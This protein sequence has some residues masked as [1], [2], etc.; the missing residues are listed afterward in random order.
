MSFVS[1]LREKLRFSAYTESIEATQRLAAQS[2][3]CSYAQPSALERDSSQCA[4]AENATATRLRR[5]SMKRMQPIV[6][7]VA[8]L[9]FDRP[10]AVEFGGESNQCGYK[11]P[12]PPPPPRVRKLPFLY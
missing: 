9:A 5:E 11:L 7:A 4:T 2:E 6:S 1:A 8:R 12:P 10:A 3:E